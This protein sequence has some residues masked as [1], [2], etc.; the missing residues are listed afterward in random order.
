[1]DGRNELVVD[2]D[3]DLSSERAV[4]VFAVDGEL[5]TGCNVIAE[6]DWL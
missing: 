6:G 2:I 1:V 4:L 5:P 3:L